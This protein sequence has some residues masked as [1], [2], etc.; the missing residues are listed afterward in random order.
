MR[1][2]PGPA[3]LLAVE[4]HGQGPLPLILIHG[5][6]GDAS[7]WASLVRALG[8]G[9]RVIIPELR[10]HG[11]SGQ[12]SDGQY[13]IAAHAADLVAVVEAMALDR[14]VLVGHSFGASVALEAAT[15]MPTQVAGMVLLDAA[16]DFSY[17]PPEALEG[18]IAGMEHPAHYTETVEG[19]F[20][21]AL[22]GATAE[23][24][25]R[26]RAAIMAAPPAMIVA[27]YKSL[28]RYRPTDALAKYSGPLLLVTAPT[29]SASFAL[30]E[31]CPEVPR[32]HIDGVSHWM[33][34]DHPKAVAR[35]VEEFVH[36]L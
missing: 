5:M 36:G 6:A 24:E 27:M 7:F 8:P 20:D 25:R 4:E 16:G 35:L 19:A 1:R 23:T 34:M 22:E 11:R 18:F 12:P 17:V 29:N 21:V 32:R 9:Y 28:L 15:L 3:G 33:M 13:A 31:L 14:V 30:H 26:V 2:L 10:G